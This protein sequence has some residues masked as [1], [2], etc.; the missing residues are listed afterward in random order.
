MI[1]MNEQ[2]ATMLTHQA[3]QTGRKFQGTY[4]VIK[5]RCAYLQKVY[6]LLERK[7]VNNIDLETRNSYTYSNIRT[8]P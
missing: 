4:F 5:C 3:R 2:C 1:H 7:A 8:T 6:N